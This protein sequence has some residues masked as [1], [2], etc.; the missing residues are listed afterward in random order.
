MRKLMF[1]SSVKIIIYYYFLNNIYLTSRTTK[2]Y[3]NKVDTITYQPTFLELSMVERIANQLELNRYCQPNVTLIPKSN[4]L[5]EVAIKN[6][7]DT[8]NRLS[9]FDTVEFTNELDPTLSIV[10]NIYELLENKIVVQL[11]SENINTTLVYNMEFHLNGYTY[12]MEST[13]LQLVHQEG[14]LHKLFPSEVNSELPVGKRYN[15]ERWL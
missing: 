13:A 12:D 10:G 14:I 15:D 5:Y 7:K 3:A 9:T 1:I 8:M 11:L 6:V 4:K 2:A